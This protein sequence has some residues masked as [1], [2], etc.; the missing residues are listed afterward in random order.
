MIG[1]LL[2]ASTAAACSSGGDGTASA[3][4]A[5]TTTASVATTAAPSTTVAEPICVVAAQVGDSLTAIAERNGITLEQLEQENL[6]DPTDVFL[7]GQEF[8]VCV[9]D[10]V[11]PADP[12]LVEPP[13]AAV[14]GQ[15]RGPKP[16]FANTPP[17]PLH[18]RPLRPHTPPP[19][20][21]R[22]P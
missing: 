7:P 9:G 19:L 13:P 21:K 10:V 2:V 8:D 6:L 22:N 17:P 1:L 20:P 12:T 5:S 18:S 4:D 16:V 3:A 14:M 15:Q 11:D